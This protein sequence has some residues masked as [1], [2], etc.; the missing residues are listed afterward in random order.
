ML[1]QLRAKVASTTLV[2][3]PIVH[4]AQGWSVRCSRGA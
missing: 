2:T 3:L 1:E 4:F